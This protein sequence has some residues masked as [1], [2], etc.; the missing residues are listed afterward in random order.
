MATRK[1]TMKKME[2][3]VTRME[4]EGYD[5][6]PGAV[7][8]ANETKP[9]PIPRSKKKRPTSLPHGLRGKNRKWAEGWL[10]GDN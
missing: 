1:E 10:K 4:G 9:T 8:G 7:A 3:L 6:G 2:D 5:M